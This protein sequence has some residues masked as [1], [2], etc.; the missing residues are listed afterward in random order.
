[1]E[2]AETMQS[3]VQKQPTSDLV[4]QEEEGEKKSHHPPQVIFNTL[5]IHF[6]IRQNEWK[7]PYHN[8]AE[9][10]VDGGTLCS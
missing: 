8:L 10:K 6:K 3:T 5:N 2:P 9:N 7:N 1:M 4:L